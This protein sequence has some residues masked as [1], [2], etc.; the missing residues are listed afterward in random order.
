MYQEISDKPVTL[1]EINVKINGLTDCPNSGVKGIN[2][3]FI[4]N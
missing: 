3:G 2:L 1:D 4:C